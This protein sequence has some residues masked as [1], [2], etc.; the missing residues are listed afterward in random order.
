M[1]KRPVLIHRISHIGLNI[2]IWKWNHLTLGDSIYRVA[3]DHTNLPSFCDKQ[4]VI[5]TQKFNE[6]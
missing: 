4:H 2:R 6:A 1:N 3:T 5:W